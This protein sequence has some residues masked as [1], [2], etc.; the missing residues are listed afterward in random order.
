MPYFAEKVPHKQC[1]KCHRIYE[2]PYTDQNPGHDVNII[3]DEGE[4]IES[5]DPADE[6]RHNVSHSY[7]DD[8]Y[9][10]VIQAMRDE[11]AARKRAKEEAS[12]TDA[13]G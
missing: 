7:C 9:P 3:T 5:F 1:S 10:S 6:P 12:N 2:G 11:S 4:M 13:N 8:C